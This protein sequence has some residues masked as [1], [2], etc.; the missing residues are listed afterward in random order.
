MKASTIL[1]LVAWTSIVGCFGNGETPVREQ[2]TNAGPIRDF[3][4]PPAAITAESDEMLQAM[5]SN[6]DGPEHIALLPKTYHG[7]LTITRPMAIYGHIGTV[8]EGKGDSTVVSIRARDVLLD[9]FVIRHSGRKNTTEDAAV[10]AKGDHIRIKNIR[11]EHSLF[12]V[13]L[14]ECTYC[15]IVGVHIIGDSA[16]RDL[17]GDG[18]KLWEAHGS[19]VRNC[20]IEHARDVVVWYTR[21]ATLDHNLVREGRYGTHLMYAHD[22][23]VRGSHLEKNI[24]GIFVMYSK[25]MTIENNILAGARGPAGVGL[26]FKDS[27]AINIRGNW[28][29]A[30]TTG[31]YLDNTPRT[32]ADPVSFNGNVIALNDVALRLHSTGAGLSFTKNSF[33]NNAIMV[34]VDGGGN[35]LEATLLQN[36]YSD[37]EGYDLDKNGIGDVAYEVKMLSSELTDSRPSLKFFRGTAAMGLLDAVAH[38]IPVFATRRLFV[39]NAPR[40]NAPWVRMP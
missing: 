32:S 39:D 26:G 40:I 6:P 33:R 4:L 15:E 35:A 28:L 18:I 5:I 30:N 29:V 7:N 17:G 20:V 10:K 8:L 14:E 21:H 37:Y 31:T 13:L 2:R 34:E 22:A 1:T 12:G 24:V 9:N 38:A 23:I 36:H 27:D 16:A 3:I 25:R 19:V 11:V